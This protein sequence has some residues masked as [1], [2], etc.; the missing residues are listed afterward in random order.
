MG[1]R[2]E[3][4]GRGNRHTESVFLSPECVALL[5]HPV[6]PVWPFSQKLAPETRELRD[7]KGLQTMPFDLSLSS[8]YPDSSHQMWSGE[9][10]SL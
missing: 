1:R 2:R 3:M 8:H 6:H 9:I 10:L 5:N 4:A 7:L